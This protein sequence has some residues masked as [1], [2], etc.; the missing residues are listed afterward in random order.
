MYIYVLNDL[1]QYRSFEMVEYY[2]QEFEMNQGL[3]AESIEQLA[4]NIANY[5]FED[6]NLIK[7]D[8]YNIIDGDIILVYTDLADNTNTLQYAI[9]SED[10]FDLAKENAME[11]RDFYKNCL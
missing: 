7:H 9:S 10:V 3:R 1:R 2:V 11:L 5:L 6:N 4:E 8:D